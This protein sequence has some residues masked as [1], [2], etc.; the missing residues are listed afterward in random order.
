MAALPC[1]QGGCELGL[2]Q[3]GRA[4]GDE[5]QLSDR[6]E[7]GHSGRQSVPDRGDSQ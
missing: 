7:A 2:H 1:A 5:D 3:D 6:S 4:T